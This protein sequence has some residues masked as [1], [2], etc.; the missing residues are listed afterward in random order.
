MQPGAATTAATEGGAASDAD[1][2]AT[3][4]LSVAEKVAQEVAAAQDRGFGD[5]EETA[6]KGLSY[7]ERL[8][9]LADV[10]PPSGSSIP[11][12]DESH[13]L[14]LYGKEVRCCCC[15]FW[16]W[17]LLLK[18]C[19]DKCIVKQH[20]HAL[21]TIPS[22]NDAIV[23]RCPQVLQCRDGYTK[24]ISYQA[25][26]EKPDV[27]KKVSMQ[28]RMVFANTG[29]RTKTR[30]SFASPAVVLLYL[31]VGPKESDGALTAVVYGID[32]EVVE[33]V[34]TWRLLGAEKFEVDKAIMEKAQAAGAKDCATRLAGSR[35]RQARHE[36][37]KEQ[38]REFEVNLP[39]P[40]SRM[41]LASADS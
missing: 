41:R 37:L 24:V 5:A 26:C 18:R 12:S 2:G 7:K 28:E 4:A 38:Q 33:E 11:F 10:D 8:R 36:R 40:P 31:V 15:V 39:S 32:S 34:K 17:W 19:F 23:E 1:G 20:V 22:L 6:L 21:T 9:M 29:L 13:K 3:V 16:G 30:G 27:I 14:L 25:Y 35:P